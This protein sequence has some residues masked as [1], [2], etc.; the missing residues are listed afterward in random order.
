MLYLKKLTINYILIMKVLYFKKKDIKKYELDYFN[1]SAE[2]ID[3]NEKFNN[4]FLN[5][6]R[7]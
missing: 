7:I 5:F 6:K 4:Y 3:D 1:I 2:N